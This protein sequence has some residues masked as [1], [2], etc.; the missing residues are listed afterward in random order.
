[1][2]NNIPIHDSN[3]IY[4]SALEVFQG[5]YSAFLPGGYMHYHNHQIPLMSV[6][7]FFLKFP[8]LESYQW[9][10]ILNALALGVLIVGIYKILKTID[11]DIKV[12]I[13]YNVAI[14]FCF[15]LFF[16]VTYAYGEILALSASVWMLYYGIKYLNTNKTLDLFVLFIS[17]FIGFYIRKNIIVIAIAL[18][19]LSFF[20]WINS[21]KI[22]MLYVV[23]PVVLAFLLPTKLVEL[24]FGEYLKEEDTTPMIAYVTMGLQENEYGL[25]P[26]GHN[27]YHVIRFASDQYDASRAT[28]NSLYDIKI[29]LEEMITD[30]PYMIKFFH[31]KLLWQWMNPD[32]QSLLH[33][34]NFSNKP[35][36]LVK[37]IY[38]GE[39]QE[40]IWKFMNQYQSI[41]Y[42]AAFCSFIGLLRKRNSPEA[43][44][45]CIV[46][47]G[48]FLLSLIWESKPRY[49]FPY[50]VML[51]PAACQGIY[52]IGL[53][54]NR[55]KKTK[56]QKQNKCLR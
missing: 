6:H 25:G 12:L 56:E 26:G 53:L 19:C 33:T 31:R 9:I 43:Y 27:S 18:L 14:L 30:I 4:K 47:I 8:M 11:S 46:F 44:I 10:Q 22:Q 2:C 20:K 34:S 38:Y 3:D 52:E 13:L 7:L 55:C 16:Y 42:L 50:F 23:F 21:K 51:I 24:Q 28:Y 54:L 29:R 17:S 35:E 48:G 36:G 15:P 39:Y 41:I 37:D 40:N 1:M 45:F 49:T 32:Y 5:D